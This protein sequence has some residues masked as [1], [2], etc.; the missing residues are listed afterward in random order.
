MIGFVRLR[1]INAVNACFIMS[2]YAGSD[3]T[4][5]FDDR[6]VQIAID[7]GNSHGLQTVC[8][9][10][11]GKVSKGAIE[12]NPRVLREDLTG[13]ARELISSSS[14]YRVVASV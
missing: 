3:S 5:V 11:I 10:S 1:A 4:I 2:R 6:L 7:S 9:S 8:R 12:E 13:W 14:R